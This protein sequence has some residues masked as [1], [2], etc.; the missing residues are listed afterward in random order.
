[1]AKKF[2]ENWQ[3]LNFYGNLAKIHHFTKFSNFFLIN[4]LQDDSR[5]TRSLSRD[6]KLESELKE[7]HKIE[8][9]LKEKQIKV[10]Q[11]TIRNLQRKF[12]E[13]NSKEKQNESKIA[14][15]E[16]SVRDS[17]V[18]ELLLRT[19]IANA[20]STSQSV[21]DLS[22]TSSVVEKSQPNAD[23]GTSEVHLVSLATAFLVIHPHGATIET[24]LEYIHEF[25]NST[26]EEEL[27]DVLVKHER[28]FN[29]DGEEKWHFCGFKVQP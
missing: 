2:I 19:K 15:L 12:I 13:I 3:K 5:S 4:S 16:E 7:Q 8:A 25:C 26:S 18:K 10:L 17:N 6:I 27:V 9:E 24:V 11:E 28:I 29:I 1:M 20:R 22:E 14:E 23:V 21:D